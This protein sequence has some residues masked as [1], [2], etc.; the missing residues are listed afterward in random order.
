MNN[1]DAIKKLEL[2]LRAEGK[3]DTWANLADKFNAF[4]EKDRESKGDAVRSV[5]RRI[6]RESKDQNGMRLKSMW[7]SA[8]GEWLKSYQQDASVEVINQFKEFKDDFIED[9][10]S[11]NKHY[12]KTPKA[13]EAGVL[14]EICLPDFHFGK[15]AGLSVQEQANLFYN[16]LVDLVKKAGSLN[17]E[18]FLLPIGN[19]F[20]NTDNLNYTTTKGTQQRDNSTWQESFRYGWRTV[21]ASINYLLQYAP[22][23]I[24]IV[25]GNHDYE[26]SF[27]LGDLLLAYFDSNDHVQID[28]GLN[29][30]RKYYMY[31]DILIGFTHGDKEKVSELPL[32]M[33]TEVP[34]LWAA[35]KHR[36]FHT[37][38]LHKQETTEIQTVLIRIMPALC[39]TDEWHKLM[40]YNSIRKAQ[41]YV[42]GAEGLEGY[43]QKSY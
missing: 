10:K 33:A 36:E 3:T 1:K 6:K 14:Y 9:I 39:G 21:I 17:I 32:L 29:S 8:S 18:K 27:Y 26:K 7:Q 23:D 22:V 13:K 35:A 31:N 37:G 4:Q 20:F 34:E 12:P 42:W 40:G 43:F 30:P 38:H 16:C 2:H 25:Q 24:V 15:I 11:L 41:G 19:D 5:F 28:N